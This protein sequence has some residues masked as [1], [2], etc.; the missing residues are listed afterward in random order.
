MWSWKERRVLFYSSSS[1]LSVLFYLR[2]K[3]QFVNFYYKRMSIN[4]IILNVSRLE[5]I[6]S[7]LL[8]PLVVASRLIDRTLQL[9]LRSF[10]VCIP[11]HYYFPQHIE[12]LMPVHGYFAWTYSVCTRLSNQVCARCGLG[13]SL[14]VLSHKHAF[15]HTHT[16]THTDVGVRTLDSISFV[17]RR[18]ILLIKNN[19]LLHHYL[20]YDCFS[21]DH[22]DISFL[23]SGRW[24]S[25][26]AKNSSSMFVEASLQ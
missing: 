7:K 22:R 19:F 26:L 13:L 15:L 14:E 23:M 21:R 12:P 16:H 5:R 18:I 11:Y 25:L 4:R 6:T 2:S 20:I 1:I 9:V 8:V 24:R 10:S 17:I 3:L